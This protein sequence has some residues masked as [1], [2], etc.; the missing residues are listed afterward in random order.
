MS[1]TGRPSRTLLNVDLAPNE[2]Q[3]SE[4]RGTLV[5]WDQVL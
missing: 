3:P 1:Q 4:L 2:A 5:D